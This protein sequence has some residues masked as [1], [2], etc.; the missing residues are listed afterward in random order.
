MKM[1]ILTYKFTL[2][3]QNLA[4]VL[5]YFI[6]SKRKI[7]DNLHKEKFRN[8]DKA[9]VALVTEYLLYIYKRMW[10]YRHRLQTG[11]YF[12]CRVI[13]SVQV[14]FVNHTS[15]WLQNCKCLPSGRKRN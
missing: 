6:I 8:G 7:A 13:S 5:K 2:S 9:Y 4:A 14:R 1:T 12:G 3:N 11:K 10:F 15:L